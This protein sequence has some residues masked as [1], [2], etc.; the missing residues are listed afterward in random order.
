[1]QEIISPK[2]LRSVMI[3]RTAIKTLLS[4]DVVEKIVAFQTKDAL[5]AFKTGKEVNFEGFGRFMFNIVSARRRLKEVE[6]I[7]GSLEKRKEA[8]TQ[9]GIKGFDG[10]LRYSIRLRDYIKSMLNEG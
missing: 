5:P 8:G 2:K 9:D 7:I 6:G 1:M 3:T 4:E 10:K